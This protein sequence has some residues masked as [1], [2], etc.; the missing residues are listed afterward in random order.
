[1]KVCLS[2]TDDAEIICSVAALGDVQLHTADL[3]W[4]E[5]LGFELNVLS[6]DGRRLEPV[7]R[8]SGMVVGDTKLSRKQEIKGTI[9]RYSFPSLGQELTQQGLFLFWHWR[10]QHVD[11][12]EEEYGGWL[13]IPK[14]AKKPIS[15]THAVEK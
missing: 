7:Y 9:C 14:R 4:H 8:V 13:H 5:A 10:V 1:M 3:P 2:V 6:E 11:H 12:T 15:E